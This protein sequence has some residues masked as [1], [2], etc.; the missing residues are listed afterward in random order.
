[1]SVSGWVYRGKC[2]KFGDGLQHDGQMIAFEYVIKRITD[3]AQLIP[4]L[5]ETLRPTFSQEV[6]PG[7]IVLAGKQF[8]KGKAHVQAYIAMKAL[9]LAVVCESMPY[10]TYRALIG[11]GFT[12]MNGCTGALELAHEGDDLEVDFETGLFVNHTCGSR[13]Q[14]KP[15]PARA[16]DIVRLGGTQGVLKDWWAKQQVQ[17]P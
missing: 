4:H 12:F 11:T 17:Q 7:D 1:M 5:F 15:L 8:G 3:P 14:F 13:H 9:G 6:Q 2:R 10:N 16:L